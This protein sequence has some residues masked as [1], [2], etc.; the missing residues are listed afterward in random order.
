MIYDQRVLTN[1]FRPVQ[2]LRLAAQRAAQWAEA[3]ERAAAEAAQR[4]ADAARRR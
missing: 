3:N 1:Y 4:A 2:G